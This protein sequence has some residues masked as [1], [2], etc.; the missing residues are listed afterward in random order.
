[1]L[2]AVCYF[3][4]YPVCNFML[5]ILIVLIDKAGF[6]KDEIVNKKWHPNSTYQSSYSRLPITNFGP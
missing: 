3:M 1:M 4:L 2:Y 6:P 5:I